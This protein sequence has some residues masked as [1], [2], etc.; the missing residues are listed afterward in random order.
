MLDAIVTEVTRL[1]AQHAL[2]AYS[3]VGVAAMAEALPVVG[4][5]VPGSMLIVGIS[6]LAST[7][8]LASAPLILAAL[9]GA[10]TGDGISFWLGHHYG[11]RLAGY[12]PFSRYPRWLARAE[13]F[14]QRH[15]G[16][17]VFLARF[18]Q[19]PRA[20]VPL[21]AGM[22]GMSPGRF[23]VFNVA[24]AVLWAATHVL[25]GVALGAS[26]QVIAQVAIRLVLML[27][28]LLLLSWLVVWMTRRVMLPHGVT[29]LKA[30]SGRLA[31]WCRPRSTLLQRTIYRLM[32]SL[33]GEGLMLVAAIAM[34][35]GCLWMFTAL[36]ENLMA[37]DPLVR[38]NQAVFHAMQA[39][40][41]HWSDTV[42]L[43]ITEL[44]DGFVT[45]SLTIAVAAWLLLRRAWHGALYWLA[46]VGGAALFTPVIKAMVHWPRPTAGLYSGWEAFSF[47]SGHATINTVLY[48]FLAYLVA[49]GLPARQRGWVIGAAMMTVM[50]I[51]LSRLYLGA[52][53]LADVLAGMAIG[54]AWVILLA[55]SH[56]RRHAPPAEARGVL[57]VVLLTLAVVWPYH[58]YQN[59]AADRAR[60]TP[61][62]DIQRMT[63][64]SWSKGGY[65]QL[66]QRRIDLGGDRE[67]PMVMQWAGGLGA[68]RRS[69]NDAGW[70]VDTPWT[71]MSSLHW[72]NPASPDKAL[73][74]LPR[75]NEG[76][77]PSL[78]ATY[79]MPGRARRRLV[80]YVW[81]SD[82][83]L[84]G[85]CQ[86]SPQPLWIASLRWQQRDSL[87]GVVA[88]ERDIPSSRDASGVLARRLLR[89]SAGLSAHRVTSSEATAL[90]LT[91]A[92]DLG[93]PC[94]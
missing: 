27:G 21:T 9:F 15:G 42:M 1:A 76:R 25:A 45:T 17:G 30:G 64:S 26:L 14:F 66:P 55:I 46:A 43:A 41:T 81:P 62:P 67:E 19:G 86:P 71:A 93:S 79:A 18:I 60:Y 16:K 7:G 29:W 78:I 38:A 47:P 68:L 75:L 58:L 33:S 2:M 36:L 32:N 65:Q 57:A 63:W 74:A 91:A 44:G 87:L 48:G 35:L 53:W 31:E 84:T 20:F 50:W 59:L 82:F 6:A 54:T 34:L 80:L 72:L 24:S 4:T 89:Q 8:A 11:A 22:S 40:R 61:Q 56:Q 37:G 39:L 69:L 10:I 94:K 28:L 5:L 83:T 49:R 12:W 70:Q 13:V 92:Q 23:Y 85:T 52:H 51:A 90:W 88:L 3:L 73:P 77:P